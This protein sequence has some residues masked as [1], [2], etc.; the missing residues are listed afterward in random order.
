MRYKMDKLITDKLSIH[1]DQNL[2]NDL[3]DNFKKIENNEVNINN[4]DSG[5]V[6]IA[7]KANDLSNDTKQRLD[8][9]IANNEQP[10]EVVDSRHS[11]T[12]GKNF[13]LLSDRL[14]D[15]EEYQRLG[16]VNF[17]FDDSYRENRLT[18][19]V[20]DE[21]GLICD[22]AI[23][24]DK[25]NN[26][27]NG[28]QG[29]DWYIDAYNHG[30]GIQSHTRTHHDLNVD[31]LSDTEVYREI[32]SS[33]KILENLGLPVSGFVSPSSVTKEAYSHLIE[34]NYDYAI[35][36]LANNYLSSPM[37]QTVD[38]HH[39]QRMSLAATDID[40]IKRAIDK[41][42]DNKMLLMFYDH[43]TG[44]EGSAS[45]EKLREILD[46]V[47]Q[48]NDANKLKVLKS[49]DAI[50]D[51]FKISPNK[52]NPVVAKANELALPIGR[53]LLN[54]EKDETVWNI[55][56]KSNP[57][58]EGYNANGKYITIKFDGNSAIEKAYFSQFVDVSS[59]KGERQ[60]HYLSISA[61][62][63][64]SDDII[65]NLV[66]HAFVRFFNEDGNQLSEIKEKPVYITGDRIV[67]SNLFG[68][69]DNATQVEIGFTF[70]SA[71]PLSGKI[72]LLQPSILEDQVGYT[73]DFKDV[74]T[75]M[76]VMLTPDISTPLSWSF[77]SLP[78][79]T[80]GIPRRY[81][82]YDPN[83]NYITCIIPGTYEF[84][85]L[86]AYK[87]TGNN[88]STNPRVLLEIRVNDDNVNNANS[89]RR[90]QST[91]AVGNIYNIDSSLKITLKAGDQV[92]FATD[93]DMAGT[94]TMEAIAN[95]FVIIR[96]E[97]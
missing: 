9:F 20:F 42:I 26:A 53:Y 17:T 41:T 97:L 5:V 34:E 29:I 65:H 7:N 45:E 96:R 68:Y 10:S 16:I 59:H 12:T 71:T 1:L 36:H 8:N 6:D 51:F 3:I 48:K 37:D 19:Q 14:N 77:A 35:N 24:T 55:T 46:Y 30:Y 95:S 62:A 58:C 33:K 47:K 56:A 44:R 38:R 88:P 78:S 21:Y 15:I 64:G 50:S 83:N 60:P 32:V 54:Q 79:F 43:R 91:Q 4:K 25:V 80:A 67:H 28:Y 52:S 31:G 74:D 87:I 85:A 90:M 22:F 72:S 82:N 93:A 61:V 39:L 81:F 94:P 23:I 13:P 49:V 27:T 84:R 86:A 92:R 11:S 18:K 89:L 73:G 76:Q 63:N 57:S 40:L 75:N 66:A 70:D 69:P 2:R